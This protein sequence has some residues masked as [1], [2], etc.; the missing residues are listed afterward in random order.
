MKRLAKILSV[1]FALSLMTAGAAD[2]GRAGKSAQV[3]KA[4]KSQ[5]LSGPRARSIIKEKRAA[6]GKSNLHLKVR[7][8]QRTPTRD[9]Y[10]VANGVGKVEKVQ[11]N[12]KTEKAYNMGGKTTQSQARTASKDKLRKKNGQYPNLNDSGTTN[13]GNYRITSNSSRRTVVVD[14]NDPNKTRKLPAKKQQKKSK[15]KS[16]AAAY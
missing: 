13:S 8:T 6:E 3:K 16:K 7:R 9:E 14:A 10:T 1:A 2:A 15:S 5:S 4:P 12:R 11:I